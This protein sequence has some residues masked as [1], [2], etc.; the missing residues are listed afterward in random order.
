MWAQP[1][2]VAAMSLLVH[3]V[4]S[5]AQ[6]EEAA[7]ATLA[8]GICALCARFAPQDVSAALQHLVAGG[9]L[10]DP[11]SG[12]P[13]GLTSAWRLRMQVRPGLIAGMPRVWG[14]GLGADPGS[15]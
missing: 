8:A 13:F 10:A 15:H 14:R 7:P 1:L 9:V 4:F 3:T 2:Q 6:A 5:A 11:Q 12:R